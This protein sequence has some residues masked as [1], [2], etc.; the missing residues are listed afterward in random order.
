MRRTFGALL[1]L[2]AVPRPSGIHNPTRKQLMVATA[3]FAFAEDD[4]DRLT[5]WMLANIEIR[6]YV[7]RTDSLAKLERAVGAVLKP[8]LDQE[9]HPFW[10]PNPWRQ[11]IAASRK[12]VREAL[13]GELRL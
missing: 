13:R 12:S 10:M 7:T 1:A 5:N 6:A 9:R 11:P 2:S 8:P 3:N 4:E